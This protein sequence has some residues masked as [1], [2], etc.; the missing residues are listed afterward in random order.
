[1]MQQGTDLCGPHLLVTQPWAWSLVCHHPPSV[2]SAEWQNVAA[3]AAFPK[4]PSVSMPSCCCRRLLTAG[5]HTRGP[6]CYLATQQPCRP[7]ASPTRTCVVAARQSCQYPSLSSTHRQVAGGPLHLDAVDKGC[8]LACNAAHLSCMRG[9]AQQGPL[10]LRSITQQ[11]HPSTQLAMHQLGC[12]PCTSQNTS[13]SGMNRYAHASTPPQVRYGTAYVFKDYTDALYV[14]LSLSGSPGGQPL[15]NV[16][17]WTSAGG[18]PTPQVGLLVWS[19][20]SDLIRLA[21][22]PQYWDQVCQWVGGWVG[23][24]AGL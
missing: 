3:L 2:A 9:S 14:T 23:P 10:P 20:F 12:V 5:A 24:L 15:L 8:S 6:A 22:S 7:L 1:M 4:Q 19:S 16:P 17:A 13:A 18:S 11:S 21:P